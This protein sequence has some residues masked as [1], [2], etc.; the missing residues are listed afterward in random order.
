MS[1]LRLHSVMQLL[2]ITGDRLVI[3]IKVRLNYECI[4][5]T[6]CYATVRYNWRQTYLN[7]TTHLFSSQVTPPILKSNPLPW[8]GSPHQPL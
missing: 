7:P 3:L 1:T 4:K 2:G 5:V 8:L 6:Q